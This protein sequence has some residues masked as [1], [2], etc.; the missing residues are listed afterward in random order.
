MPT[1]SARGRPALD[2]RLC[3][4]ALAPGPFALGGP[5]RTAAGP[6][7][8]HFSEVFNVIGEGLAAR[9]WH[10]TDKT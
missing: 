6:I 2:G 7:I 5:L 4:P 9:L 1:T 3:L 10:R 8:A